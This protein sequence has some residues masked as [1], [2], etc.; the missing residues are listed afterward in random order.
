VVTVAV[1]VDIKLS[2][3]V[4]RTVTVFSPRASAVTSGDWEMLFLG[5]VTVAVAW[6]RIVVVVVGSAEDL[7]RGGKATTVFEAND[8]V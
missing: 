3:T 1:V 2:V 6:L 8:L 5:T 4:A 7:V